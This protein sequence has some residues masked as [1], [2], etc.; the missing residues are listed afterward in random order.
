MV[1][2]GFAHSGGSVPGFA[3]AWWEQRTLFNVTSSALMNEGLGETERGGQGSLNSRTI[4]GHFPLWCWWL[5]NR[6]A[7]SLL[8]V[9]EQ[10]WPPTQ[11]HTEHVGTL[12]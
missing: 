1:P 8:E 5:F 10:F 11:M 3:F 6:V 9:R 4:W 7:G 12:S 2:R